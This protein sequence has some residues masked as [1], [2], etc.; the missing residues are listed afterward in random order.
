[1]ESETAMYKVTG[2]VDIFD[3]QGQITGQYPVGSVQE[4]SVSR[5]QAAIDAGQA[6][7]A[8]EDEVID[9]IGDVE[10]ATGAT[11]E[12]EVETAD[13]LE[14]EDEDETGATGEEEVE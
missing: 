14:E 4:L 10:D 7:L 1:M 9:S 12:D 3:E 13:E 11:G 5:G 6:E 8:S 2:L